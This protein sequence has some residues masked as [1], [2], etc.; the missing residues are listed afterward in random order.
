MIHYRDGHTANNL[1]TDFNGVANFNETFPLFNWYVV[2]S[3]T[4]R[5]KRT[6]THTVYDAGG[7]ADG[8]TYCGTT[9]NGVRPCG[10]SGA[11]NFLANT[12]EAVPLPTDL[13]VPGAVYCAKADC[14]SEAA[15][16]AAGTAKPSTG[17]AAS[18]STGRIDPPWVT[19][20]GWAGLTSQ[21]NWIDFGFAPYRKP[22]PRRPASPS[23]SLD[24]RPPLR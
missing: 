11:Y 21:G 1:A 16:F 2:E 22:C 3:D 24:P 18:T 13:S 5:Y 14:S 23:L 8:T 10:T 6:G 19:A 7:P 4:T 9:T 15:T 17:A 12:Y 20:E